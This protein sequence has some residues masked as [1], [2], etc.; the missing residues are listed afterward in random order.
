MNA[1]Q[2]KASIFQ[3]AIE[4]K[5]VPQ[6]GEEGTVARESE[7]FEDVPFDIPESWGWILVEDLSV[8]RRTVSPKDLQEQEVE[9]WSIPA[10][11]AGKPSGTESDRLLKK[12]NI[13][14]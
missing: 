1:E 10:Y 13:R 12:N 2:L 4:G 6:L 7:S 8:K 11:D 14:W 3:Q 9:L 5:L